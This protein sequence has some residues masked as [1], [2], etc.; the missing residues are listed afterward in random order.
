MT[1]PNPGPTNS[2]AE[3]IAQRFQVLRRISRMA[4]RYHLRLTVA[5]ITTFLAVGFQLMIPRFLGRSVDEAYTLFQEGAGGAQARGTLLVYAGLLLGA[6]VLRGIFT[7]LHNYQ[8]EAVGQKIGYELRLGIYEKIQRLSFSY[9][10][11]VHSGDLITRG[12]LDIE[13][14]QLFVNTGILRTFVLT[15]LIGVGAYLMISADWLLGLLALSFVPFVGW[16]AIV[17]RLRLR[18]SWHRLQERL[19]EL[20]RVI[21]ENLGGIRVVRAFAAQDYELEKFDHT[22]DKAFR[23]AMRRIGLQVRNGTAMNFAFFLAMGLVLLVG[24]RMVLED[25]ITIGRLTEFLAYMQLLQMPVR[26][27]GPLVNSFARATTSGERLFSVLDLEPEIQDRPGAQDL[28]ITEGRL[29]FENVSFAYERQDGLE[30]TLTDVNFEVAPGET[31]GIVG[32]PGAGKSTIA[33]LIPR[34]YDVTAG[35][36]TIDDQDIRDVT[37]Q[38]LRRAVGLIQ[39]DSFIFTARIDN[40]LAY[41]DPW[42][43]RKNL[44]WAAEVSQLHNYIKQLPQGYKTL[45]GERGLSLSGGQHQRLAIARMLVQQSPIMIFDDSTAAIDAGTEQQIR[46]G[47][48]QIAHKHA[49]IIIAHRLS[50]LMH[51]DEILFVDDGRIIERGSHEKLIT[52]GGRYKALYELQANPDD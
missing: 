46:Q 10:D 48:A 22:S 27:L 14:V 28:K 16:R 2:Q 21:E 30:H 29:R 50:S 38:S 33:H 35:R 7:M 5:I 15:V 32:P 39:Q 20:T 31:V 12:M 43:E 23:L 49:T 37:L 18:E 52:L 9:H 34:F 51:A 8:G 13:G 17:T 36:I 25:R 3:N 47:L 19:G 42:T 11:R 45:V 1:E 4:F 24:G 44:Q 40:N 6:N 41:G 26:Q